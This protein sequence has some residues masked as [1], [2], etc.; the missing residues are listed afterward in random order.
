MIKL[1]VCNGAIPFIH[2]SRAITGFFSRGGGQRIGIKYVG[3]KYACNV[4]KYFLGGTGPAQQTGTGAGNFEHDTFKKGK[5]HY[6]MKWSC[7][8]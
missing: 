7:N 3:I 2:C 1:Y 5:A 4:C 6:N 8:Y